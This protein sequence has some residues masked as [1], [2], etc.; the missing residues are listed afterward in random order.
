MAPLVASLDTSHLTTSRGLISAAPPAL[1]KPQMS[2]EEAN[3]LAARRA[4]AKAKHAAKKKRRYERQ[5]AQRA[6]S[7]KEEA[8]AASSPQP[9]EEATTATRPLHT[10]A[11]SKA[12]KRKAIKKAKKAAK[13]KECSLSGE[14]EE[15]GDSSWV[16]QE[17]ASS[18]P[19]RCKANQA[20][21]APAIGEHTMDEASAELAAG[22]SRVMEEASGVQDAA[23]DEDDEDE[24]D[25]ELKEHGSVVPECV[26]HPD[27]SVE[28][29][30]LVDR[31]VFIEGLVRGLAVS[32]Q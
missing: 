29:A 22:R 9:R 30:R 1:P 5:V 20:R 14:D 23:V 17:E 13:R 28:A 6:Q 27:N 24:P 26:P 10:S 7:E 18:Q 31:R 25:E 12:E 2:E 4:K 19:A 21:K 3:A 32:P 15:L 16:L 8:E 11:I